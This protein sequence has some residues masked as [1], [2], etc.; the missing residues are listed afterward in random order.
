LP[1]IEL[2]T[3]ERSKHNEHI[4]LHL[5]EPSAVNG[6]TLEGKVPA[7]CRAVL[8][9]RELFLMAKMMPKVQCQIRIK[10]TKT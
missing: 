6:A 5:Q 3:T 9:P 1:L 7:R 8:L 4:P 10:N 2:V